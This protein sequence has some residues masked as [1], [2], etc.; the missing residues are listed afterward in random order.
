M[1]EWMWGIKDEQISVSFLSIGRYND[2]VLYNV[3]LMYTSHI[4]LD[5]L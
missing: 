1:V 3:V 4:L 2:E 5:K